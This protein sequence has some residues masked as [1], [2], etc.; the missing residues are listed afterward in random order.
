MFKQPATTP[1][2]FSANASNTD[3]PNEEEYL[4]LVHAILP[5]L[6]VFKELNLINESVD[7]SPGNNGFRFKSNYSLTDKGKSLWKA[8]NLDPKNDALPVAMRELLNVSGITKSS[9]SAATVEFTWRWKANELGNAFDPKSDT[10]KSL[11]ANI[12]KTMQAG[13]AANGGRKVTVDFGGEQMGFAI[14]Q[15]YDDGWRV[16]TIN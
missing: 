9:A 3:F 10:F 5:S 2:Q 15:K 7:K 11:P 8:Y 12:Q 6:D 16:K 13:T 14:L 4:K 1:I